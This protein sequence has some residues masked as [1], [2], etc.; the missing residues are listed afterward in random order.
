MQV[1]IL[2]GDHHTISKMKQILIIAFA[3]FTLNVFGQI[4]KFENKKERL[5]FYF[6]KVLTKTEENIRKSTEIR[7]RGFQSGML[8]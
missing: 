4:E 5:N 3:F 1:I 8:E 2:T 6:I 7:L